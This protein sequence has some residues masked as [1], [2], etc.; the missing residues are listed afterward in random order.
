MYVYGL[1]KHVEERCLGEQEGH[2]WDMEDIY[3]VTIHGCMKMSSF[4]T[5]HVQEYTP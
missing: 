5:S 1:F 3:L 4:N 2:R